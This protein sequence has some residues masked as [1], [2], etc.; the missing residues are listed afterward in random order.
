VEPA[1][2]VD[3]LSLITLR[4]LLLPQ[5]YRRLLLCCGRSSSLMLLLL[6]LPAHRQLSSLC[7]GDHHILPGSSQ[8][9]AAAG[10]RPAR[11][12][13]GSSQAPPAAGRQPARGLGGGV[14]P[15]AHLCGGCDGLRLLQLLLGGGQLPVQPGHLH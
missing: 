15:A 12:L 7:I 2:E 13:R 4:Q 10:R 5:L 9:P 8:A 11:G 1:G 6:L 3:H 14:A